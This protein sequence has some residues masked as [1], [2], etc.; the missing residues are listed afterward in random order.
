MANK[1]RIYV[2]MQFFPEM[3][4]DL[5]YNRNAGFGTWSNKNINIRTAEAHYQHGNKK[6]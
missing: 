6:N 1:L 2:E 3:L 5:N 4:D